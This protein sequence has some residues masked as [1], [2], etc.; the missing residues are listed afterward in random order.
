MVLIEYKCV[1]I[2]LTLSAITPSGALQCFIFRYPSE[3]SSFGFLVTPQIPCQIHHSLSSI[4]AILVWYLTF[5]AR[6]TSWV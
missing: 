2:V 5:S 6:I 4:A 1:V 3:A